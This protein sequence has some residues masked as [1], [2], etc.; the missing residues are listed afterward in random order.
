MTVKVGSTTAFSFSN[1]ENMMASYLSNQDVFGA[2]IDDLDIWVDTP[3][4]VQKP[5]FSL[6]AE[7]ERK[8]ST[9][10]SS[11]NTT[12]IFDEKRIPSK[13]TKPKDIEQKRRSR[14]SKR[15][16]E[17]FEEKK[18]TSKSTK[19]KDAEQKRR[20]RSC[21]PTTEQLD[22][23]KSTI[24][25]TKPKDERRKISTSGNTKSRKE[26]TTDPA[27]EE[28]APVLAPLVS[29]DAFPKTRTSRPKKP[30]YQERNEPLLSEDSLDFLMQR[31]KNE[32]VVQPEELRK[33]K[34]PRKLKTAE[35]GTMDPKR[36]STIATLRSEASSNI[37]KSYL[38][39]DNR[40]SKAR[41][42]SVSDSLNKFLADN[43]C[44]DLP[45][46]SALRSVY[47]TPAEDSKTKKVRPSRRTTTQSK[48]SGESSSERKRTTNSGFLERHLLSVR[49]RQRQGGDGTRSV[50]SAP[51]AA[52]RKKDLFT[53][54]QALKLTF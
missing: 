24:K 16:P 45:A 17:E 51:V 9:C 13:S 7:Q 46:K 35:T 26:R 10:S 53:R 32:R 1:N 47:S 30:L 20:S 18:S 28:L 43:A 31:L 37:K 12:E 4:T 36:L 21:K 39:S 34:T 42:E 52:S 3:E 22:E 19:P 5:T 49:P 44:P 54:C 29:A 2:S 27:A 11:K 14:S 25:S 41:R 15:T 33:L 40:R 6:K 48:S 50:A 8:S 38:P 23:K